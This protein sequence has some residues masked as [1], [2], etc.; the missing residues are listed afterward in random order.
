MIKLASN[1]FL[2]TKI[3]FINEIADVSEE[4]GARARG[5]A[6]HRPR[7][8]ASA[9]SSCRPASAS[10]AGFFP[11]D[12]QALKQFAGNTSY[13]FQLLTSVIEV[14]KLPE[15][16]TI[17]KLQKRLGS[18]VGKQFGSARPGLQ[19]GTPT[20]CEAAG[21]VSPAGCR[22]GAPRCACRPGR[23]SQ[24]GPMLGGARICE[25]ALDAVDG[26]CGRAG[27]GVARFGGL[28]WTGEVKSPCACRWWSTARLPRPRGPAR[29]RLHVEG[30][31]P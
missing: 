18:L 24:R 10:A 7:R 9:P 5:R 30:I 2:A 27:H 17:S 16:R 11:A 13:H 20:T 31:G 22:A 23:G 21:L 25:S 3:S 6:R 19:A 8:P 12:V 26:G 28:D 29:G 1:A 14:N 15:A 4:L